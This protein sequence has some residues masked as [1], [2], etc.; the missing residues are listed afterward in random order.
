MMSSKSFQ[1]LFWSRPLRIDHHTTKAE[2]LHQFVIGD[3]VTFC[4]AEEESEEAHDDVYSFFDQLMYEM[5]GNS[6]R[7]CALG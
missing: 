6:G 2:F 4:P 3:I 1:K 7:G 5:G